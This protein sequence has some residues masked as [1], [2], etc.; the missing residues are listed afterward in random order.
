MSAEPQLIVLDAALRS[1]IERAE[2][3]RAVSGTRLERRWSVAVQNVL[4][5]IVASP[6]LSPVHTVHQRSGVEIRRRI[7]QDFDKYLVLYH[8]DL[9]RN[10]IRVVD[11]IHGAQDLETALG[12]VALF[13]DEE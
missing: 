3:Y 5:H 11:I 7:L 2:H 10:V 4:D 6:L 13:E 8:V 12:R 1:A 9:Q